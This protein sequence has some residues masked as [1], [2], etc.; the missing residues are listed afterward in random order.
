M[1][2]SEFEQRPWGNFL[3]YE[4]DKDDRFWVKKLTINPGQSLS[5]QKHASRD[6]FWVCVEGVLTIEINGEKRE[7]KS[8]EFVRIGKE[9][10]HRASNETENNAVFIEIATGKCL[11]SDNTRL[12]DRYGRK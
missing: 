12:E 9:D 3:T 11:E 2:T 8:G 10:T 5:L 1:A 7:L 6:E 4:D